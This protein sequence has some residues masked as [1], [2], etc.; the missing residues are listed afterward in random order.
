MKV[1]SY[2][3][4]TNTESLY[5]KYPVAVMLLEYFKE[6]HKG[7]YRG[8][9]DTAVAMLDWIE[10][11]NYMLY[12]TIDTSKQDI[13]TGFVCSHIENQFGM[14]EEYLVVDYMYVIPK[15]RK[16]MVSRVLFMTVG[17]VGV[18]LG[19]DVVGCAL[20]EG[21]VDNNFNNILKVG[22]VQIGTLF[23]IPK[24]NYYN[25]FKKYMKGYT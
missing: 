12:F 11:N 17:K 22:G 5:F 9:L 13:V 3:K 18:T 21:E 10:A 2:S 8:T 20:T 4:L 25:K 19:I 24:N 1:Y 6:R 7:S 16:T 15:Y 23:S 14:L